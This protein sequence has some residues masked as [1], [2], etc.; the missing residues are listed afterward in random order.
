MGT[1]PMGSWQREGDL[2]FSGKRAHWAEW[3]GLSGWSTDSGGAKRKQ[4]PRGLQG[5]PPGLS[6]FM[7]P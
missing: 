4:R 2:F 3:T 7:H 5:W 6:S 1:F